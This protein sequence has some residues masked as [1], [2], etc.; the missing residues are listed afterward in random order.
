MRN[1]MKTL[2]ISACNKV[3]SIYCE[4]VNH[5]KFNP[6]LL[7]RVV[8]LIFF[9]FILAYGGYQLKFSLFQ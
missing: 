8:N 4:K 7:K 5:Q 2:P 6:N 1:A 9:F 3:N